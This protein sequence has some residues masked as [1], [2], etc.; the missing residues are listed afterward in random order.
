MGRP[1]ATR[2]ASFLGLLSV[3]ASAFAGNEPA[4]AQR[5][6]EEEILPKLALACG[7]PVSLAY[8]GDS[9]RKN[10]SDIGND[11]TDGENECNE[12]LRYLWYACKSEAG[13]AAVRAAR[14]TKIA[15][16]GVAG[17]VGSLGLS[18][19]TVTVERA[20]GEKQPYVRSR[21]QFESLLHVPLTLSTEDPYADQAWHDVASQP[22]PVTSTTTYCL[23]GA[24]KVAYDEN[25]YDSYSRRH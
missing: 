23:V 8:D 19:G 3:A 9:L 16:R 25:V 10:N 7:A 4:A 13:K 18:S 6:A 2:V 17:S 1:F 5:R 20:L 15:C 24:D 22:N 14:I 21:K 11:Q 12:P